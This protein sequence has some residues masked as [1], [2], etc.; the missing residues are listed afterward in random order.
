VSTVREALVVLDRDLRVVMANQGFCAT[1]GVAPEETEGRRF[2][3][4][5]HGHWEIPALRRLLSDVLRADGPLEALTV[6]HEF[7]ALGRRTMVLNARR[8]R[9]AQDGGELILL[10]IEGVADPAGPISEDSEQPFDASRRR[11]KDAT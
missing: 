2:F 8:V 4:L 6:T 11:Q 3:E 9:L 1:M 5:G 7:E 10:A